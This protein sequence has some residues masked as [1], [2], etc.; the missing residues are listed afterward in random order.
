MPDYQNPYKLLVKLETNDDDHPGIFVEPYFVMQIG[1]IMKPGAAAEVILQKNQFGSEKDFLS[2]CY[3]TAGSLAEYA[4][5][6]WYDVYD[7]DIVS[8][9]GVDCGKKF[10]LDY[11]QQ[12]TRYRAEAE[13]QRKLRE[14][15]MKMQ[16]V[17]GEELPPE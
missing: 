11:A 12:K 7:P 17:A 13:V 15:E 8:K 16:V 6:H 2:W 1:S 9:C 10:L 4:I 3:I 5:E 14:G